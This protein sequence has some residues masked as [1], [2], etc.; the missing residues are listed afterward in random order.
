M[1]T[2]GGHAPRSA[3]ARAL[4]GP[5]G[6]APSHPRPQ[7]A[8]EAAV[9]PPGAPRQ[10]RLRPGHSG[11]FAILCG[12]PAIAQTAINNL[13]YHSLRYDPDAAAILI[14]DTP[15]G[16]ALNA[17]ETL[18]LP[19]RRLM[20]VTW[21][22]CAEYWEDLWDRGPDVL[23]VGKDLDFD[24]AASL[25]QLHHGARSRVAPAATTTLT[26][27]ERRV[28]RC[29]AR[30]WSNKTIAAQ[31]NVQC[32]TVLNTLTNIYQKIGVRNRNE[33]A[34]YYWG[35]WHVF[36]QEPDLES[37]QQPFTYMPY[38]ELSRKVPLSLVE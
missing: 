31:L 38:L 27:T 2:I 9:I 28:L 26:P 29:V 25:R 13:E 23:L 3:G 15:C 10:D 12:V 34:L 1:T 14:L 30:G 17:L 32:Q 5:S 35:I 33:A 18:E 24:L 20:V 19:A 37:P 22:P 7:L 8:V 21:N 16:F 11:A 6:A 36:E 4:L